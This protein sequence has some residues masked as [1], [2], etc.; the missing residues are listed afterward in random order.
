MAL[1]GVRS[2]SPILIGFAEALAAPE[3]AMSLLG[4]GLP[5]A[6]F[7]RRGARP[8]LR[9]HPQV[10]IHVVTAPEHDA[11]AT[12][13]E[14]RGLARS[15]GA[16]AL[17]PLDDAAVWL[18]D[19]T[20]SGL[21]VPVVGPTG[22]QAR[23][24]LDKRRQIEAARTAGMAVPDTHVFDSPEHSLDIDAFPVVL[25]PALAVAE[26]DGRLGKGSAKVCA[27]RRELRAAVQAWTGAGPILAQPWLAGT[28]EGLFGLTVHGDA[29]HWSAHR[30]LR[31]VNPQGSGSS[32]CESAGPEP[33]LMN[34]GAAMMDAAGWQGL[35]MLE[36]LRDRA[37]VAWFME[38]NGRTW[39][40]LALARRQG[41]EYPAWAALGALGIGGCPEGRAAGPG[42]GGIVCRHLGRE[43]LHTLTVLR[44]PRSAA[45]EQ[46]PSRSATLRAVTRVRRSDRWYN[47]SRRHPGIF[48]DD[49]LQTVLAAAPRRSR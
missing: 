8:A 14:L 7:T 17:M 48:L 49:T 38:L 16:A 1:S 27:G 9:R 25:K 43:I 36:F 19:Q 3:T 12:V 10:A 35:F 5:V 44:G 40:S 30:R 33:A 26:R 28:G 6:A 22:A 4:A 39:G 41:F 37:G 34:A 29:R 11:A 2:R 31:M 45:L 18:C 46:W 21:D 23:L 20:R 47:W 24:A 42:E 13:Q 32:A 15:L